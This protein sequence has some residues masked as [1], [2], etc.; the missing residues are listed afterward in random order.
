VLQI[1]NHSN[2]VHPAYRRVRVVGQV[3]GVLLARF[4]GLVKA[5]IGPELVSVK[6]ELF[7]CE[8]VNIGALTL[9]G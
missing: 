3:F 4:C 2:F 6:L 1:D 5:V 8:K 9:Y 7:D